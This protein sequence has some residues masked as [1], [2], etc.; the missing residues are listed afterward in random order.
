MLYMLITCP[1]ITSDT[2]FLLTLALFNTSEITIWPKSCAFKDANEPL[3][4]PITKIK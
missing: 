2:S 4:E 1:K 3:N